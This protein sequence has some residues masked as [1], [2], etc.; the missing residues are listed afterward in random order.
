MNVVYWVC[1]LG[2]GRGREEAFN[3][4]WVAPSTGPAPMFYDSKPTSLY[5]EHHKPYRLLR[6]N[7]NTETGDVSICEES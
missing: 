3:C 2:E 5:L 6:I 4:V 7:I 1:Y